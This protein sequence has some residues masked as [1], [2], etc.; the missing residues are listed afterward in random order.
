LTTIN[1]TGVNDP[2]N[3]LEI[4]SPE[5]GSYVNEDQPMFFEATANDPDLVYGDNLNFRWYS[6][7]MGKVGE[8][9]ILYNFM[10]S[11]GSH[12]I[13]VVVSD[14]EN[15]SSVTAIKLF[16]RPSSMDDNET[17]GPIEND[18]EGSNEKS[19]ED[20]GEKG[21][22]LGYLG[23]VIVIV[24]V[25]IV[26]IIFFLF[27]RPRMWKVEKKEVKTDMKKP[28][29]S[30]KPPPVPFI[31]LQKV[32]RDTSLSYQQQREAQKKSALR[33]DEELIRPER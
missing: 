29:L 4:L 18:T 33:I 32:P 25:I 28:D 15:A 10:L 7:K 1:I 24:I 26:F 11:S 27:I 30:R 31:P 2:P 3:Q 5:N 21:E 22:D 14:T 16:V 23:E 12:W 6:D 17:L 13:S 8:G 19:E 20:N 9:V